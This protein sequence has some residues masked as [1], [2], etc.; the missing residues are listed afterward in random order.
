MQVVNYEL[1]GGLEMRRKILSGLVIFIFVLFT[2]MLVPA[3]S[4]DTP[5]PPSILQGL[6]VSPANVKPPLTLKITQFEASSHI[7]NFATLYPCLGEIGCAVL[8]GG[9]LMIT[10]ANNS[11]PILL[12][13][14]SSSPVNGMAIMPLES[15]G[16]LLG[17]EIKAGAVRDRLNWIFLE[18]VFL[19]NGKQLYSRVIIEKNGAVVY[20]TKQPELKVVN[21]ET[22]EEIGADGKVVYDGI[23]EDPFT[24]Q[25]GT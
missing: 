17:W 5:K 24:K 8:P 7:P 16:T 12:F 10:P 23:H 22:R 15:K 25:K 21:G 18:G 14:E 6:W 4:P 19:N 11:N 20:S 3:A 2:G 1:K 9:K 13:T